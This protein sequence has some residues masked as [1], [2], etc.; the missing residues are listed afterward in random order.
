[1]SLHKKTDEYDKAIAKSV[2]VEQ[3]CR[4]KLAAVTEDNIQIDKKINSA[5]ESKPEHEALL[6]IYE[7]HK[8]VKSARTDLDKVKEEL[9]S[10]KQAVESIKEKLLSLQQQQQTAK[11]QARVLV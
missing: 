7:A 5:R 6:A 2:S 3:Q 4:A 1:M 9:E 10:R 8:A 11:E